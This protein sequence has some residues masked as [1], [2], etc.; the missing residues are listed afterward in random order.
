MTTDGGGTLD[1][2]TRSW[3]AAQ[4]LDG[5][6]VRAVAPLDGGYSNDMLLLTT[7]RGSRYVLRRYRSGGHLERRLPCAVERAVV[8]RAARTA[9]VV[10][11]RAADPDGRDTGR[12]TL[13]YEYVEGE[14]LSAVLASPHLH[15]SAEAASLGRAVG[16][17]LAGVATVRFPASGHFADATLRPRPPGP[18]TGEAL[19]GH[20][21]RCLRERSPESSLTP[22]EQA[23]LRELAVVAGELTGRLA[24][25][26][27]LVHNDFNPKNVLVRRVSG[28]WTVAA[29]LDWELAYSGSP[30]VD[31]GNMLRFA[32]LYPAPFGESVAEAFGAAGGVLPADWRRIVRALDLSTLAYILTSPPDAGLFARA[33]AVL[34][35]DHA[36]LC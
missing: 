33:R 23:A 28:R 19:A 9:P 30:L 31:L 29:V 24:E 11:V 1:A 15:E 17:V 27:H 14:P 13:L 4:P 10:R 2:A 21:E 16:A 26:C 12:P 25:A 34:V 6:R 8:L 22:A 18:A 32:H 20:V 3:L 36:A 7:E 35:R 5:G